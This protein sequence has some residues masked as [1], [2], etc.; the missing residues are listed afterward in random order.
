MQK[1]N[2]PKDRPSGDTGCPGSLSWSTL[3]LS[4]SSATKYS[5]KRTLSLSH[6][7]TGTSSAQIRKKIS[8]WE[9]RNV[10]LPRMSLC[11]DKRPG[12]GSEGCPSLLSSPCSEKAFDFKAMR[13][14]STAY[15]EC[16]YP[17]TEEE[18]GASDR[19]CSRRFQRRE[20]QKTFQRPLYP[21]TEASAVLN[22][23]QK[24]E[25]ALKE[26]PS[27]PP[28]YLSN[29]YS[30]EHPRQKSRPRDSDSTCDSKRSSICSVATEPDAT[31]PGSEKLARIR[32]RF[33]MASFRSDSPDLPCAQGSPGSPGPPGPPGAPVNPLPKP[34]RTFE[35]DA[36]RSHKNSS[37]SNGVSSNPDTRVPP[38]TARTPEH[39]F[40]R[41][42]DR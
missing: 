11:L 10:A 30:V 7:S 6:N 15:S 19:E 25:R 23:I 8:E 29:C 18:D 1:E 42:A 4:S 34:K 32:H 35:Y 26:S 39:F 31:H 33:S 28:R 27:T 24:I 13:R 12:G 38:D 17:E 5:H 40:K 37:P 16:S 21:R 36:N 41:T 9:C 20:G 3:S 2:Q 22:R 14:M